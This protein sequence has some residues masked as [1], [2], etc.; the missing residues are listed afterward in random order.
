M[1]RKTFES[2]PRKPLPNRENII[3]TKQADYSYPDCKIAHSIDEALAT[4][5]PNDEVFIIGGAE[6]Y[7]A[8]LSMADKMY[9]THIHKP[10]E[11][12]TFFPE[13]RKDEWELVAKSENKQDPKSNLEYHFA[14]YKRKRN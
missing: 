13:Y 11:A 8:F 6:I 4:C 10:F 2:F 9:L 1:G 7:S 3:I 12:D 14:E 5:K